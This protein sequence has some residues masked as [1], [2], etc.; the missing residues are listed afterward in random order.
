M[1]ASTMSG[2]ASSC[3]NVLAFAYPYLDDGLGLNVFSVS[4][5]MKRVIHKLYGKSGDLVYGFVDHSRD[6]LS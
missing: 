1:L 5:R 3:Y 2:Y 4:K 6:R